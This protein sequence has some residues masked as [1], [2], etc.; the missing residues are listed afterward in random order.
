MAAYH[1]TRWLVGDDGRIMDKNGSFWM[2]PAHAMR[3][4]PQLLE[5]ASMFSGSMRTQAF[6]DADDLTT[7]IDQATVHTAASN[8]VPFQGMAGAA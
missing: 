3:R 1:E 5:L 7:A 4:M 2:T 8:V 6:R